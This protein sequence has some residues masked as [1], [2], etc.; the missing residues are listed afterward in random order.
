MSSWS[1]ECF[2]YDVH[3]VQETKMVA[4]TSNAHSGKTLKYDMNVESD[5]CDIFQ[6]SLHSKAHLWFEDCITCAHFR[7]KRRTSRLDLCI[8][9]NTPLNWKP[10]FRS[11]SG[12]QIII[13]M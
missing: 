13:F 7:E 4:L 11:K 9:S 10:I 2:K 6:H 12:S 1:Y 3:N 8:I 5:L